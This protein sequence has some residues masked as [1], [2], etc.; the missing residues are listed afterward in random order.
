[1]MNGWLKLRPYLAGPT[2][3][4]LDLS[5]ACELSQLD[6]FAYDFSGYP[7][8]VAWRARVATLRHYDEVA[9]VS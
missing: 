8:V 6:T 1:M 7:E 3:S 9:C 2:V 5:A 4:I